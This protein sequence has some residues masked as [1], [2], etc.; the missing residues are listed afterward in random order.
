MT[1][2]AVLVKFPDVVLLRSPAARAA[3]RPAPGRGSSHSLH[4]LANFMVNWF[5]TNRLPMR[6]R[7]RAAVFVESRVR[8]DPQWVFELRSSPTEMLAMGNRLAGP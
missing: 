4:V 6:G 5:T 1:A 7:Y 2:K 8:P 3:Q